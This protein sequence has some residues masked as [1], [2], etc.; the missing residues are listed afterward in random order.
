MSRLKLNA[1]LSN[2]KE[3]PKTFYFLVGKNY[4]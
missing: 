2:S 4:V 3:K 1:T